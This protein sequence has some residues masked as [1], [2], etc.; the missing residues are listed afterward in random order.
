MVDLPRGLER[1]V[2]TNKAALA[3]QEADFFKQKRGDFSGEL[4]RRL[5]VDR[6]T[7]PASWWSMF[8]AD[9]PT[10]QELAMKLL[11][12]CASSSGCERN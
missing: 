9:T 11:S 10:L 3:L 12:Q 6:S 1:M 7:S 8:G 5:T 2:D 4:A